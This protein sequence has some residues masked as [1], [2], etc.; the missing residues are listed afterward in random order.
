MDFL[1]EVSLGTGV[2][3]DH[4]EGLQTVDKSLKKNVITA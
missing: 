4:K 3:E 1:I 2:K